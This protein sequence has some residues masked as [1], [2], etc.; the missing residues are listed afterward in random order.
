MYILLTGERN[1]RTSFVGLIKVKTHL[2]S[3]TELFWESGK[4]R[5]IFLQYVIFD[6]S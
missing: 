5:K 2:L 3:N 4:G 1:P 6:I